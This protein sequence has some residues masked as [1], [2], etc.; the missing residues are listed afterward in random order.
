VV[1]NAGTTNTGAVDPL[2][3]LA[4]ICRDNGM[5]LHTDGAYGAAAVLTEEGKAAL[6]GLSG[7]DSLAI[8]PHKWLFCPFEIGCI[9]V[10]DRGLL[11]NAFHILPDYMKDVERTGTEVNFCDFGIQLSRNFRALKL[12]LSIKVFGLGAFREAVAGGIENARLAEARIRASRQWE[13]V[14]P[15]QLGIVSF[16]ACL[17]GRS[18]EEIDSIHHRIVDRL[19]EEAYAF[20]SSTILS[21]RT[22][23]R[24]CTINPTTTRRDIESTVEHLDRI[25]G[26]LTA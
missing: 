9:L 14:T 23:L 19:T 24:M 6:A 17:P 4:T 26:E 20:L 18:P 1:A 22:V 16:R 12:W 3:D 15:A 21:G 13:I 8:D 5:W 2:G 11:K 10:R 25:I 7:T